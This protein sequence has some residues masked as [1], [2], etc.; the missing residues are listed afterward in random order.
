M[1]ISPNAL[2]EL[3]RLHQQVADL[4]GRLAR[5]PRQVQLGQQTVQR[6]EKQLADVKEAWKK[7]RMESD[8][9]Q[10][11]LKEREAKI[12]NLQRKLNEC[13][14]NKEY[15]ILKEQIAAERQANSVLEDEILDK[16]EKIDQLEEQ[17]RKGEAL[18][19][20]A[21]EELEKTQQSVS[22]KQGMLESE[23]ARVTAELEQAEAELPAD[24]KQDYDRLI[25]AHGARGLAPIDGES[26]TGC[27][28]VLTPQTMNELYLAKPV[29]CKFCG[30]LLY[31]PEDRTVGSMGS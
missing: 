4:K 7:T 24:F 3:H 22:G 23:L 27:S 17:V 2:R 26:C 21:V 14:E 15:K 6:N 30:C 1:T 12:E 18:L 25:R 9:Q 5:G 29:F 8:D 10:V 13:K 19:A 16:L 28:T 11:Q 20:K 31:L